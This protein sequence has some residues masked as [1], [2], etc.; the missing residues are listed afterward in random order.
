MLTPHRLPFWLLRSG[1]GLGLGLGLGTWTSSA[2]AQGAADRVRGVVIQRNDVFEAS[3]AR[4]WAYRLANTLHVE[5]RPNVIRRELLIEIGDRY[6]SA[7]V[8]ESERNLRA[9]G[10]F[11]DVH[12]DAVPTDTGLVLVVRTADAWT[13]TFG[14]NVAASGGAE[15]T[16]DL[17]LQEGNLLGT[18]TAAQVAYR[19][20]PDRSSIAAGFDTPRAIGERIGIGASFVERSDGRGGTASIRRPFLSLSSRNGWSLGSSVFQG[21]VLQFATGVISDSLWRESALLRL[22]AATAIQADPRGFMRLGLFAQYLRDDQVALEDQDNIPNSRSGTAGP[23]LAIRAP[24]Y[25]RARNVERIGRIEDIDLGVFANVTLLAAPRAWGYDRNGIGASLG[26]G[27]GVRLPGLGGFARFGIRGSALQTSEGTDSAT[28][29]AALSLVG[30]RGE[31][32][33]FVAHASGGVQHN[34]VPGREFDLG[35]GTGLRAYPAHAFT[36]DRYFVL[37]SEYRYLVWPHLF[38]VV[39]VGAAAFAGHAGAW[40]GGDPRL[41]GTELGLGLRL[42][43]IREAGGIW[44]LDLSR[45]AASGSFGAGWVASLGRGFVFGGI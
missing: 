11:R 35:L 10:I 15:S 31:R 17:S 33:L 25:V 34:P 18:R 1:L 16:I 45:R 14:V 12:I 5:T 7:L 44:R 38:G 29:E 27:V 26:A 30:Q 13:T 43:S 22:D 40:N 42:A 2:S 19:N 8:A 37:S 41:T 36:G 32:H 23:Y 4:N 24:R 20:D 6:D 9:L 3:E 39:G 21:R 28:A